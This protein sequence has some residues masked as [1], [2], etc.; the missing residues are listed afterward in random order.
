MMQ[1]ELTVFVENS[2]SYR[3][4]PFEVD[5]TVDRIEVS[6]SVSPKESV[7]DLGIEFANKIR[8]WSGSER[9]RIFIESDLATPGY[10][11]GLCPGSWSVVLGLVTIIAETTVTVE[12]SL[13]K[14]KR[15]WY[16]GDPHSHTHHSDGRYSL[17]HVL[18]FGEKHG[19]DYIALTDHNTSAQNDFSLENWNILVIPGMEL[20][21]YWGHMAF[22]GVKEP[23]DDIRILG[24]ED[25]RKQIAIGRQ[26][27]ALVSLAHPYKGPSIWEYGYDLDF[28][29][30]E[31]WNGPWS[32]NNNMALELWQKMLSGGRRVPAV[33]GSDSHGSK[34]AHSINY[35]SSHQIPTTWINSESRSVKGLVENMK[36]G[37]VFIT[38]LPDCPRIEMTAES[39]AMMGDQVNEGKGLM[40]RVI[41]L[42]ESDLL[43]IVTDK[44]CV[45]EITNLLAYREA[46]ST[47]GY[48]FL[49]VEVWRKIGIILEEHEGLIIREKEQIVGDPGQYVMAS[50]SNPVYIKKGTPQ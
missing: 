10:H 16:K 44:G 13:Q 43:R 1:K 39:E 23:V 25:L 4:I 38:Y 30:Y 40:V 7:V 26:R 6:Y 17:D 50:M 35:E 27:G 14:K 45:R 18:A 8:G 22:L 24:E 19:F 28:D 2:K 12:I 15:R 46:Y 42:R 34:K 20:T 11:A 36:K 47:L 37:H 41:D 33:G 48:A 29:I 21:T 49:R 32:E 5:E 31:V 9:D 3:S